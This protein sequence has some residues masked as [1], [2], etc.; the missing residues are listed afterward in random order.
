MVYSWTR[1]KNWT[2]GWAGV[3]GW[4]GLGGHRQ[5]QINSYHMLLVAAL[6]QPFSSW[7]LVWNNKAVSFTVLTSLCQHETDE[8]FQFH[9]LSLNPW[10]NIPRVPPLMVRSPL[11][12]ALKGLFALARSSVLWWMSRS[13]EA[14]GTRL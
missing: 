13:E 3:G 14:T 7:S 10:F 11:I 9:S 2:T 8:K 4:G 6:N 5:Q 12:R 1:R